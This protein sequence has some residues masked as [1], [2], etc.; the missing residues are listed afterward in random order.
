MPPLLLI[1]DGNCPL[2]SRAVQWLA[3]RIPATDLRPL[4][5]GTAEHARLAPEVPESACQEAMH[6]LQPDGMIY[7]GAEAFPV[8]LR[9]MRYGRSLAWFLESRAGKRIAPLVYRWIARRRH[10]LSA[11]MG[12]HTCNAGKDRGEGGCD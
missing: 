8:L 9:R 6:L 12:Y 11:L 2:C 4:R 5:C 1:Y 10:A 7:V 3:Q